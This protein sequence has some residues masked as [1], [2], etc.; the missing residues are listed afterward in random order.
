M[1]DWFYV[2]N[3]QQQGPVAEPTLRGWVQAGQI[4]AD[5]LIWKEGM[6]DWLPANQVFQDSVQAAVAPDT[7]V[8]AVSGQVRPVSDMLQYGDQFVSPEHKD[9]FLQELGEGVQQAAAPLSTGLYSYEDPRT[10]AAWAKWLFI[11]GTFFEGLVTLTS[12]FGT[13]MN[14]LEFN[15]FDMLNGIFAILFLIVYITGIVFYCMWKYRV[16]A[17]AHAFGGQ[18]D[19]TPGWAVGFY[20]IPIVMLWKPFQAMKQTWNATFDRAQHADSPGVL[21]GWWT[22]W[23]ISS[24]GGNISFRLSLAGEDDAARVLDVL[25]FVVSV[26]LLFCILKIIKSITDAQVARG[27]ER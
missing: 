1:S 14:S 11:V 4:R 3:G 13:D 9:Q 7:A 23:L 18:L 25:L 26:C 19:I 2:S 20:F 10:R 16:C 5:S 21:V 12:I 22:L 6:G 8:C 24:F 17:N 15:T 27:G